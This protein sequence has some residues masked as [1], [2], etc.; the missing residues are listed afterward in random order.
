MKLIK[1]LN[2]L[3]EELSTL[4]HKKIGYVPTMGALHDG[5]LSLVDYA[6]K[7]SDYVVVSIFVNPTQFNN[8]NDL[9]RYPINLE[10]DLLILKDKKV[11]LV[12]CPDYHELY[13]SERR[14]KVDLKGL[15][16][17]LEGEKRYGHF[18][19]VIRVL[20]LFF[21]LIHPNFAF[22]GEKDYQQFLIVDQLAKQ[23][24]PMIEIVPCPTKRE[25]DGLAMSSR[26][27]RLS[28]LERQEA[29]K[30]YSTLIYCKHHFDKSDVSEL[31]SSCFKM[32]SEFSDPEYF[33]IRKAN[34]LSKVLSNSNSSRAFVATKLSDV[35]LIDNIAIN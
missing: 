1:Q 2:S 34:D 6:H 3:Q 33:E 19:G 18:E 13:A 25:S 27:I 16:K 26:N 10:N 30:I 23:H 22:F 12:F 20:N 7:K 31:E 21:R 17:V 5:H 35:R 4:G 29:A 8:K 14:I 28:P 15:D 32:I 9:Q 24:F 11:D